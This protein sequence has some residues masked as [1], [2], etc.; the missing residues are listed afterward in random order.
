MLCFFQFSDKASTR[1]KKLKKEKKKHYLM[2]TQLS[3]CEKL[4]AP[5]LRKLCWNMAKIFLIIFFPS[6][7]LA[8]SFLNSWGLNFS[9]ICH[10][11]KITENIYRCPES[12]F[13]S[14]KQSQN[15]I[16][17]SDFFLITKLIEF[18]L[19]KIKF[20]ISF[21]KNSEISPEKNLWPKKHLITL[22][23]SLRKR[24]RVLGFVC[25]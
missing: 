25:G 7:K 14:M 21:S 22:S 20:P 12:A 8:H 13:F 4:I 9:K 23:S 24:I 18:A 3:K 17:Y 15:L 2:M 5:K 1:E 19:E 6:I 11:N 16:K 10:K